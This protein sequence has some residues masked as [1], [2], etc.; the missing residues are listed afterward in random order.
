MGCLT[1]RSTATVMVLSIL[2]LFTTPILV[3]RKFLST[4]SIVLTFY[5]APRF[6]TVSTA[7]FLLCFYSLFLSQDSLQTGNILPQSANAHRI[8]QRR[9]RVSEFQLLQTLLI[10]LDTSLE[11]TL[12]EILQAIV[13]IDLL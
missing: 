3:L 13:K 6:T 4:V 2:L 12:G 5:S 8:F 7:I 11:I 10:L 1:L 9:D